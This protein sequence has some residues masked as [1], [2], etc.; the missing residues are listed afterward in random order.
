MK[1]SNVLAAVV[2]LG[3][4][5]AATTPALALENEF[6]GMFSARYINSNFNRTATTDYGPGD[7]TYDPSAKS[8]RQYSANFIEERA[9]LQYSAK[10]SAD[11]KL[12]T[13]FELDYSYWGNSSYTVGRNQGGALG[14]DTVNI[15]TKHLYLDAN[16]AKNVNM[17]LGMM[18]NN[19]AFKGV[20]FDADMA[21]ILLSSSNDKLTHSIGYFRFNDS[22]AGKYKS[23][24]HNTNDMFML[25]GKLELD[26]EFKIGGAYYFFQDNQAT[27]SSTAATGTVIGVM[28]DGTPIYSKTGF[29][30]ATTTSSR[31]EIKMHALGLNAEYAHGPLSLSGFF[32]Y[33]TGTISKQDITSFAGNLGAKLKAGPGTARA[34]FLYVAGDTG[35]GKNAFYAVDGEHGYYDNEMTILGRDKNAYTTDNSMIY[36]A[37]NKGQGQIGGYLGYDLPVNAKLD[38]AVN[39]G[40]AAT[41][42]ENATKPF[43]YRNG[44]NTGTKNE[45]N[46]LGTEINAEANYKMMDNLKASFR[47]GYV[48]LGDYYKKTAVDGTP[49]NPYDA[50]IIFKYTF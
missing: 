27:S 30:P 3:L 45:S 36:N 4:A 14:A 1:S 29:T 48:M 32:V 7:G 25:D 31:N 26:K 33:E 12:V 2:T 37:G 8:M 24:G 43:I 19:D 42:K 16:P 34:E 15:E 38:T 22:G 46:Y 20:L 9:R 17:K 5:A 18:P 11:L 50:K 49:A 47:V 44:V 21:G 35:S 23:L 40:F 10:A 6:H 28:A 41:A 39:L 13:Q